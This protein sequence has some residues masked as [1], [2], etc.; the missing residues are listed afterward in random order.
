MATWRHRAITLTIVAM[1]S[2]QQYDCDPMAEPATRLERCIERAVKALKRPGEVGYTECDLKLQGRF[3]IVLH[4]P[5]TLSSE[6]LQSGGLPESLLPE[7]R[8]MRMKGDP[9]LYVFST[10]RNVKG[11]GS[12]RTVPSSRT[13]TQSTFVQINELI[14]STRNSPIVTID[15]GRTQEA[16]VVRRIR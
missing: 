6:E 15:V 12:N 11:V 3:V 9:G 14:V 5:G 10:D 13:N 16:A 1:G 8:A 7:L 4:P 2:M